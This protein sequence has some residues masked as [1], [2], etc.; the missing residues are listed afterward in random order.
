MD[1]ETFSSRLYEKGARGDCSVCGHFEWTG[2]GTREDAQ[3]IVLT[4]AMEDGSYH[5]S[6]HG[7][8]AIGMACDNCGFIRLHALTAFE[9]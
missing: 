3:I 2:M 1:Y 6:G 5:A 7:H 9:S 4:A 8:G